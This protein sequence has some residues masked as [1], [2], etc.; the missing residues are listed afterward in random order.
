[1][2]GLK[3]FTGE[4][5]A[6]AAL[7]PFD[8][9]L[10]GEVQKPSGA[11]RKLVADKALGFA[12]GAVGAT[13]A[14]ADAAGAG[15]VVSNTLEEANKGINDYLSPEAK[16]DQQEQSAIMADAQ[17]KGTWE[18]IKAGAKAFAVAPVQTAV[19]GLGSIVPIVAGTAL[20]GGAAPAA[21]VGAGIGV[22]MGAGTAKGAIF[23]DIKK[24]SLASGMNEADATTAATKAQEYTGANTDQIALGGALGA[25]DALTGVSRI[26]GGMARGAL[27]KPVADVLTNTAERGIVGRAAMGMAGEMPLEAAQGGQ[28]QLAANIA[29]QRAGFQAGTWDNVGSNATLEALAS[30]GPGATFGALERTHTQPESPPSPPEVAT[31]PPAGPALQIGNTPDPYISFADGTVARQSEVDTYINGLPADQQ[32]AAR[33]KIMG[34]APQPSIPEVAPS[35]DMGNPITEAAPAPINP[36]VAMG[37]DPATG[38]MSAA[39][40]T[41]VDTGAHQEIKLQEASAADQAAYEQAMAEKDQQDAQQDTTNQPITHGPIAEAQ[42]S[43]EDKRAVLY[44]NQPVVDGGQRYEGTQNGDILNGMGKPYPNWQTAMRRAKME[45]KDWTIAKVFDGFVARRGDARTGAKAT[46]ENTQ[47]KAV[48]PAEQAQA[49]IE[50]VA[51]STTPGNTQ[52]IPGNIPGVTQ[53]RTPAASTQSAPIDVTP[54]TQPAQPGTTG[55]GAGGSHPT[56]VAAPAWWSDRSNDEQKLL[57]KFSGFDDVSSDWSKMTDDQRAT[58]SKHHSEFSSVQTKSQKLTKTDLDHLFGVD[59]KRA[60]AIGSIAKGSAYFSNGLKAQQF[61]AK[62]GLKDTHQ[63]VKTSA[64]RWDVKVKDSQ[65]QEQPSAKTPETLESTPKPEAGTPASIPEP[66]A[67]AGVAG[68]AE[69]VEVKPATLKDGIEKV[70]AKKAT[71]S[72]RLAPAQAL[73]LQEAHKAHGPDVTLATVQKMYDRVMKSLITGKGSNGGVQYDIKPKDRKELQAQ[74]D[75]LANDLSLFGVQQEQPAKDRKYNLIAVNEKT[76]EKTTLTKTPVPHAEA[77]TMKGKFDDKPGRRIQL[78]D[79]PTPDATKPVET[80]HAGLKI[81]PAN[82]KVGDKVEARWVVQSLNNAE[83]EKN[84]ERQ[85]GGDP[86]AATLDE[87]KQLAE[88]EAASAKVLEQHKAEM[89]KNDDARKAEAEIAQAKKDA[90]KGKSIAERRK[91][92]FLD[93]PTKLHPNAGLGTGTKRESMQKAVEQDRYIQSAMVR[94]E[95]AKKRDQESTERARRNNLPT[96]NINY[97]GVKEYYEAVS[98]LKADDYKKPEYRVYDGLD[99][100][101]AYREIS[102]TEYDYAQELKEKQA[103]RETITPADDKSI[104]VNVDGNQLYE[105]KDG[106]IYQMQDGKPRFSGFLEPVSASKEA[107]APAD[108]AQAGK[109]VSDSVASKVFTATKRGDFYEIEGGNAKEAARILDLTLTQNRDGVPMVGWPYHAHAQMTAALKEAGIDIDADAPTN[110]RD[111]FTLDR[112]NQETGNMEPVT[113]A[114]GEYVRHQLGAGEI[115]G[116]SQAKREFSVDGLW[117][118]FGS[119]YK[120]E[121]PVPTAPATVP[122]SSVIA[123]ANKKH[124]ADLTDADA[125]PNPETILDAETALWSR[126]ADGVATVDEFKAG[127]ENWVKGKSAILEALSKKKKDDLLKMGGSMFAY[128]NKSETKPEIVAELWRDGAS[129]YVL[130][131]SFSHGM[132][133]NAWIDG[134]RNMVENTDAD[135]LA[136]YAQQIKARTEEAIARVGKIAEAIKDPKTLE[137]YITLMRATMREGKTFKEARMMLT[138]EQRAQYDDL[139]ATDSR[140]KRKASKDEQRTSV[141]VA[142]QTV[143]GD[144][145]ATKHTKK[146]HD[147]FVVQLA[148]RVSKEDYDTLNT[149]AKR[150]GGYYSSYRGAGAVPGFQ[151]TDRAQAEAFVKLAQGDNADAQTAAQANRDAF[152]DDRSQTAVQ[153]LTE[154]ADR[155]EDMA[156]ASLNQDRKQNTDKRAR[157]AASAEAAA[158]AEKAMAKT[159]RNIA[160]AISNGTAKFL[161][162]VR[163]KTQVSLLQ[164][165]IATAKSDEL[166]AKYASYSERERHKGEPPSAETADFADFPTYT[167]SRSNL[168]TL[169]RQLLEVDGA[170]LLGQRLLKEADDVSDAYTAFAKENLGKVLGFSSR[171]GVASFGTKAEAEAAISRSGY[172]GKAIAHQVK[173]G[174]HTVIL[175]PSEAIERGIWTGDGDKRIT[176][177]QEVGAELVEKIGKAARRGAKVSVPWQL[178]T[179]HDRRKALS[180]MGIET[181]A[182]FRA[183]LR[184]FIG[185]QEQAAAPNK[186]KELERAMIGRR[187]DGMDFFPTPESV[188]DEMVAAAGIEPGMSVL[189]PSAGWGHIAERIRNNGAE[190]DVVEMSGDRRELL[191][192]KGFNVVGNDFMDTDG[193]YDRIVMNPPFSD[194]RDIQ[195]VQRAYTLLKPGGRIVAIMGES[196]FTNQNKR[197]TEFREWLEKIG[198]TEEKLAEGSFNDPSLPVNTGANARMV[199]I[200]RGEDEVRFSRAIGF[201][202]AV[203]AAIASGIKGEHPGR[204][205]VAIGSITPALKAAGI[206][207]GEL[208]TS[209]VILA[210]AVF[211]HGVTKSLLKNI[212]DLLEN[213]VMVLESDTVSGSF[214]VVTNELVNGKP[215][216]VVVSP[217]ETRGRIVFN[218]VPSVY[219]KDDLSAIQRWIGNGKLRYI[220]KKQ[221]PQWLGSTRLKLPG[222]YRTAKGLQDANVSTEVD[223]VKA[224]DET[225][226][227][228]RRPVFS[229]G[230]QHQATQSVEKLVDAIKANWE[231]AP[232]IIVAFDMQDE[233]IPERVRQEDLK[234]RSGGA[235]GTPEGFFYKGVVY[236]MSSQLQTPNDVA[237]VLFHETLGHFGLR[238]HFGKSLK[239]ILQQIV[240]MRRAEVNAKMQEYGLRNV[241]NLDRLTAAEEVLAEMAQKTPELHFVKRAIA[242]IRNWLRANVPGFSNLKLTDADIIQQYIL[243]ARAFVERG[244]DGGPKGGVPVF[245]RSMADAASNAIKSVTTMNIKERA[246]WKLTDWLG[247][248]L[249][250]LGRRQLVDIYGGVLP[251]DRYNKLAAQMEA[252]KNEVGAGADEL[253]TAWGRLKD[254]RQLAELMH[255]ATLAQIDP[256]KEYAAGDDR[257]RHKMLQGRFNTLTPEAQKVYMDA[258]G[259]YQGHHANVLKAIKERIERSELKGPRKAELLKQMDD[260]FFKAVKG[261][262]FPLARFGQYVVVVKGPDGKVSSVNRAETMAEAQALRSNLSKAFPAGSGHTVARPILSK[263][264]IA[265]RDAVGRGFMTEL[266]EVLDK[267]DMDAS[268]RA[269]LEDTLGQLYLSS[270][271]DLSWAKHGIHRKGIPGFSQDAR[272]AYAQNMFHGA[273]YLAKLRYADLMQDELTSMQKHVDDWKDVDDFDQPGAQRVV[274][275]F[276]KRHESLMNPQ[277]NPV[278]TALTSFGFIFHLG[279]SPASAMV[280]LSQTALVA[281]P[282]MGAKWGFGKASAALIKASEQA[283]KGKNDITGSLTVDERRAY[284]E[285]VRA[286]TIDVTMAHDLAGISQG[287]DAGVMWKMRPVMK[288][289]SFMFHHAE[290]FN[291]QVTFIAAY[292]LARETGVAHEVAHEQATKATYD[293]HFDYSSGNRPRIMQGNVSRVLLLFKQ[294]GQNMIYTLS[295][296]AYQSLKGATPVE[297]AEARKVLGGLLASHAAAAGVLG[298]PL[299]STLLAAASM[300]GSDDDEPWD[301]KVALQNML[302]DAFGQKPAEVLA[303]GLSRL[304]PW[305]VSGRIG[306]DRLILPDIQEG[307]EGQRLGESAMAAALGPVAGIG[308]NMLKGSQLI[309]EGHFK[310]GLEAMLPAV[311]RGPMKTYRFGTEGNIDKSGV[312]IN[313]EVG[314]AGLAGQFLGFSPS[315]ARLAQEGKSAIIGADRAIQ[316]RRSTLVRQYAL[317]ALAGDEE[318]K[319]DARKDIARFNEKN[320][321]T[322][323]LPRQLL[324]SVMNRRKRIEQAEQ[325]VYLPRKRQGAMDAGRFAVTE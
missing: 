74:A 25:A 201:N 103:T 112:L 116:I 95:A 256:A 154:M 155:L 161:D 23:D 134:V 236:L 194:G 70:R 319:D 190:P 317:A 11:V 75:R 280:N 286:G 117:Y 304:T 210:K 289:A 242:A 26:A 240:T 272:R 13:K 19:Q 73:K 318:G 39:A 233:R 312:A 97:P 9:T 10:D 156:D 287:E 15:N 76:D 59:D 269:E 135:Q 72:Q 320:P 159:M 20:T 209:P 126:I 123:A 24:R 219:P 254:E 158:N 191:E 157:Q 294:Y 162:R 141:S 222:E 322:R 152:E 261:V 193:Q 21:A 137:D 160:A 196:A 66:A 307:L 142:G 251:L 63:A 115:D 303:H 225:Q 198:G 215:L 228:Y 208:R 288:W 151:F 129:Q 82:V 291:R 216:L 259:A 267:Q 281:F 276:R 122:L 231:N 14:I 98:R 192:A 282:V 46:L 298:L 218:F 189:E 149:G 119:A 324:Q 290:R 295:R 100:K 28:E 252:D 109:P 18:G 169:A 128:R 263:E 94:D 92:A 166:R 176:L 41:A 177:S 232:E 188:A 178:E 4:L 139:A 301:A 1:M 58:I 310:L 180:R 36:S 147:V 273:R 306:L 234:Q 308:I 38:P 105:R 221:S 106:S 104:G 227:V 270:L 125:V 42:M 83:R 57:L 140:D 127:F 3:P 50:N 40:V 81:Y 182:E 250:A 175:S 31:A 53:N 264:F 183:A 34:L 226:G 136:Q 44:S 200:E 172:K 185:L 111:H 99:N 224:V 314:L 87:A 170:K 17:G 292:R 30:A 56:Q 27:R 108:T 173:R 88:Q 43:D 55:E 144:I 60:K 195:H 181:P 217:E 69:G 245:S 266:Y 110:D 316:A 197:A 146:G 86:M 107:V 33:A 199:V 246:G 203:D 52:N 237:R 145:I 253:A 238:G 275:E 187:N 241:S 163:Q 7:K 315:E 296:S 249:Q 293:G 49:T 65:P 101:G 32:P 168:A 64:T 302:A 211:D 51:E 22:A 247:M 207:D 206:P 214:V 223:I 79:A 265:G 184:E 186:V 2:A 5:D 255:D 257:M 85:I 29:A 6:P 133:K 278:S 279:L 121:K 67:V 277:G 131:R 179:A 260:E 285:A 258:R 153:R 8:G 299:V 91:D 16:A 229:R 35:A 325:G 62:N 305:D 309:S 248:G 205:P 90:N 130:A 283:V 84:G 271:P 47:N 120:A 150:I 243:P 220:D 77:V 118:P 114:R 202:E 12:S 230:A 323:I 132:G 54:V 284:D 171:G 61:I 80:T 45:G 313:D 164:G 212:P 239:P 78:E 124:G 143:D 37:L 48:T 113:F 297:R 311:L 300:P 148:E 174:E 138:V 321:Q 93:G 213:P 244:G 268:A 89:A 68:A 102:K 165:V 262:Y 71:E 167:A 235:A 204:G 274:D 96:G